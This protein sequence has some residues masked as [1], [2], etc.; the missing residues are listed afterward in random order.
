MN[1]EELQ[2]KIWDLLDQVKTRQLPVNVVHASILKIIEESNKPK[3]TTELA[4]DTLELLIPSGMKYNLFRVQWTKNSLLKEAQTFLDIN[5]PN[6]G[7]MME[8]RKHWLNYIKTK[9]PNEENSRNK[10]ATT[11]QIAGTYANKFG[12]GNK[13]SG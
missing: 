9:K 6:G 2:A 3:E 10:P 5:Y 8:V 1:R 11:E 4:A 7:D 12:K 13:E